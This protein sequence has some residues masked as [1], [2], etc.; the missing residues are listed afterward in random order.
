[1]GAATEPSVSA[2]SLKGRWNFYFPAILAA[3]VLVSRILCREPLYFGDGPSEIASIV[4]K[5]YI[6]QPPG[7]WMFD[8]IA[9][10]FSDPV[11]AMTT[12]NI[13]C[14]RS[15]RLLL[16]GL[17]LHRAVERFPGCAGLLGDLLYLVFRR[18]PQHLRHT[19]PFSCRYILFAAA[20]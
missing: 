12:I 1:M 16:H 10:L 18:G 13:I 7:Y 3:F 8:R 11:L 15:C 19:D 17:S 5:S 4:Q 6:I 14:S 2:G 9:G 20:L